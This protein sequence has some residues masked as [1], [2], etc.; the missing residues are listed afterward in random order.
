MSSLSGACHTFFNFTSFG[1]CCGIPRAPAANSSPSANGTRFMELNER[2]PIYLDGTG[3]HAYRLLKAW[4]HAE[5]W[6]PAVSTDTSTLSALL[7]VGKGK[8]KIKAKD[9]IGIPMPTFRPTRLPTPR[10]QKKA[11]A[12]AKAKGKEN[13]KSRDCLRPSLGP[14]W[15]CLSL[16]YSTSPLCPGRIAAIAVRP[17]LWTTLS[18]T[19]SCCDLGKRPLRR[20]PLSRL[21]PL[22]IHNPSSYPSRCRT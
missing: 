15:P 20:A 1:N 8:V 22:V 21:C 11:R 14:A 16:L 5:R 13:P 17:S 4:P 7:T 3:A 2:M 19:S 6:M 12:R 18:V 9:P 10:D